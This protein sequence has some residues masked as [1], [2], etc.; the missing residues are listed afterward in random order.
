MAV[1]M[2]FLLT[3]WTDGTGHTESPI[4]TAPGVQSP[5]ETLQGQNPS[6]PHP[7]CAAHGLCPPAQLLAL[8]H[9]AALR[10]YVHANGLRPPW[11]RTE[12]YPILYI[13]PSAHRMQLCSVRAASS[14]ACARTSLMGQR[15]FKYT[16]ASL[17]KR[18]GTLENSVLFSFSAS[19][20]TVHCTHRMLYT[21]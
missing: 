10:Q 12:F 18:R 3:P 8:W 14:D 11:V 19:Q 7:G 13:R 2:T 1:A 9:T 20:C 16:E 15:I 4:V 21:F 6:S 5:P 17:K